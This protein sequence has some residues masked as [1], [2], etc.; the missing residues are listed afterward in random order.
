MKKRFKMLFAAILVFVTVLNFSCVYAVGA[1]TENN[2]DVL[3]GVPVDGYNT[4]VNAASAILMDAETGT[5]L[6]EQ[7]ADQPLPPASVTKIMTLL[8][9]MEAIDNG[10]IKADDMV[11][12]S[13][14]AASMGGSQIYLE[15]GEQM[16]VED[17]V[18]SVVIASANDAAAALAEYVAGTE[19]AFVEMMNKRA[20]ELG[21]KNTNFE[22][23]NGLDDTVTN[24]VISARDI[25]IMSAEL[26]K[27]DMILKY[28]GT[29]MDTVRNGE[30]GLTNTNRLVR[31]YEG[32]TGLKTGSTSK[33]KFCISATAK[34]GNL[35]LIAV[36]MGAPTRDIRND[37][38]RKLLD[39]GF[40]TYAMYRDEYTELEDAD[41]I[42]GIEDK[43]K[44]RY[45]DKSILVP[46]SALNA[47]EREVNITTPISAPIKAGDTVGE[48]VYK[49]NGEII[50]KNNIYAADD[51]KKISFGELFVKMLGIF[52]LKR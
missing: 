39:Y 43:C 49:Y 27:Y 31:F 34:R 14:H 10:T 45:D 19:D 12:V 13:E 32:A 46:K 30:F 8:L 47:V 42:G 52:L 48:I 4:E 51:V 1:A 9:V 20:K 21:M 23:T 50:G 35:H 18:K 40:A 25:A 44:L 17:M 24:H 26:I 37:E 3:S 6:F 5:V 22:N 36:I 2:T 41:V 15:P 33:A 7:N 28:S 11:S 16:S 38:A 29:W